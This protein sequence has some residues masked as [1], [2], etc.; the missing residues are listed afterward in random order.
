[1][2]KNAYYKPLSGILYFI[3]NVPELPF[4][5]NKLKCE[6]HQGSRPFSRSSLNLRRE[7]N[8]HL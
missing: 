7:V 4:Q 6:Q 2:P 1:M 3:L 8:Y 5:R